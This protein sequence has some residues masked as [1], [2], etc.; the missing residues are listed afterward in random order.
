MRLF[1][2]LTCALWILGAGAGASLADGPLLPWH[3]NA[4]SDYPGWHYL[5]PTLWRVRDAHQ[6][7]TIPM[8]ATDRYPWVPRPIGIVVFP[9]PPVTPE[10]Y[11][12]GTGLSYDTM[13][14]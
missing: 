9:K 14:R 11:Y 5:T 8:H 6:P 13:P 2:A 4:R 12:R 7:V 3:S 10:Q 1:P